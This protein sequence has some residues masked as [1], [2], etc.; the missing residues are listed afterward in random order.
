MR[1]R[2][3]LLLAPIGLLLAILAP[4]QNRKPTSHPGIPV[5]T[6]QARD[7]IVDVVVTGGKGEPVTGLRKQD[8]EVF[9][10]GKPQSID[11]FEEHSANTL[12]AGAPPLPKMPPG[13]FT[14]VPPA[15]PSDSVNVLLLDAL[16]TDRQDQT[17]VHNQ[18]IEFL[19]HMNPETRT[20]VFTLGSRLRMIQGFTSDSKALVAAVNDPRFGDEITKPLES[21]S[22]GDKKDDNFNVATMVMMAGGMT[23]G[24]AA[25]DASQR[26]VANVQAGQRIGMTL[27][28]LQ[29]LARYLAAV[30]GRKNLIWFS[31]SF[32]V[33][34]FP[35]V[36]GTGRPDTSD[37]GE[38]G[39]SIRQT[40]DMLTVSRIAVYPIGAEGMMVEKT[41]TPDTESYHPAPVDYEGGQI[42]PQAAPM[43]GS[44]GAGGASPSMGNELD[45]TPFVNEASARSDKIMSMEQLAA[46][47]G[48][49]AFFNTNDL[50]AATQKAIADGAHYYTIAYS[51]K[52]KKMDGSYRQ[53]KIKVPDTKYKLAYRPGYNADDPSK[54]EAKANADPLREQMMLGMPNATQLLYGL[55]VMPAVPQPPANA[56]RAGKNAKLTGP[57]TRYSVDFMIRWTDVKLTASADGRHTGKIQ[58]E[59]Q[60]YD[61]DGKA[62]NWEG[63][64]QMMDLSPEVYDAVKRSGVPAHFE[65]DLP[66]NEDVTLVTGV[67]DWGTG[68]AGTLQIPL[69]GDYADRMKTVESAARK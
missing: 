38:Y 45:M 56:P 40:A 43:A 6:T 50:N 62:L 66:S 44:V 27:Q 16:N 33:T 60:V 13:V 11:F 17:Y 64:T 26:E 39:K 30:P 67:Y 35:R 10:D 42:A 24:I 23:A 28:A 8:F 25:L 4:A 65:I 14:N 61:R 32:P 3:S 21:R 53:I 52:N 51:P 68:K 63:G 36:N 22:I 59:L 19:K 58:V 7:V 31:S 49:K 37:L 48:G 46:D 29:I 69:F 5:F 20:A 55:R 15:P 54:I 41:Y 18:I 12:P 57:T 2:C 34:V 1:L 9:E 47:T